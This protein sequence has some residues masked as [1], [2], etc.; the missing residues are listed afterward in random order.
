M[1]TGEPR[2]KFLIVSHR[3]PEAVDRLADRV[4]VIPGSSVRIQWDVAHRE[5][6]AGLNGRY[7]LAFTREPY[8]WGGW[9]LVQGVP[10]SMYAMKHDSLDWLVLLT[11]SDYPIRPLSDLQSM[12]ANTEHA[13]FLQTPEGGTVLPH[14]G[15][16][17]EWTYL[18]RRYFC[19]YRWFP[20]RACDD[21]ARRA[22]ARS[23]KQH[24]SRCMLSGEATDRSSSAD[25]GASPPPSLSAL[26]ATRSRIPHHERG[27]V[28][29]RLDAVGSLRTA[30]TIRAMDPLASVRFRRKKTAA[31][32]T[33][34]H[35]AKILAPILAARDL[36]AAHGVWATTTVR[37]DAD[38]SGLA[39]DHLLAQGVRHVLAIDHGS[40]DDTRRILAE[41]HDV[42]V[43][44]YPDTA[45]YQGAMITVLARHAAQHGAEWIVPFDADECW[46]TTDGTQLADHLLSRSDD[47]VEAASWSYLPT[48]IDI[49]DENPFHRLAHRSDKPDGYRSDRPDGLT[50]VAFRASSRITVRDGNHAVRPAGQI[51]SGLVIAH[52]PYRSRDQFIRKFSQGNAALSATRLD[53]SVSGHWRVLGARGAAELGK[54]W[55][56][57]V[58][59]HELPYNGWQ[60][61]EVLV[62]DPEAR[63]L[64]TVIVN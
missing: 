8:G 46:W 33:V 58:V 28:V 41:R 7:E 52:Y 63:S 4:S 40:T 18:Q 43:I 57:F 2:I 44:P 6:A 56:N 38:I 37:D 22:N 25:P 12:F 29:P 36:P 14:H 34:R 13:A 42:T 20:Q 51:G 30:S 5:S 55:D 45:F 48:T 15:P 35:V 54:V 23:A 17:R 62:R 53:R 32:R 59:T 31:D 11:G 10:G 27:Y 26:A 1:T 24:S 21:S 64:R 49:S 60:A 3:A 47:V 19:H 50:K 61:P 16:M 39:V 9:G